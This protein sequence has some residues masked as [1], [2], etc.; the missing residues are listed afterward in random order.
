MKTYWFREQIIARGMEI[1][2]VATAEQLGGICPKCLPL[3]TFHYL[4]KELMG[5]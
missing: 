4:H 3:A 2:K 1:V 5:W